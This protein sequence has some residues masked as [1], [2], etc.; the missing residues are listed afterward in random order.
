MD[1]PN[2][3]KRKM[4]MT[5]DEVM[6]T[7]LNMMLF[8]RKGARELGERDPDASGVDPVTGS[9]YQR[10]RGPKVPASLFGGAGD[11]LRAQTGPGAE[12][13]VLPGA[14][15]DSPLRPVL[16]GVHRQVGPGEEPSAG[17]QHQRVLR[18]RLRALR[19]ERGS[20]G[21]VLHAAGARSRL[22]GVQERLRL[23]LQEGRLLPDA[24][25]PGFRGALRGRLRGFRAGGPQRRA[26]LLPAQRQHPVLGRQRRGPFLPRPDGGRGRQVRPHGPGAGRHGVP[27]AHPGNGRPVRGPDAGGNEGQADAGAGGG[28]RDPPRPGPDPHGRGP[29]VH[30]RGRGLRQGP[31]LLAGNLAQLLQAAAGQHVPGVQARQAGHRRSCTT[32]AGTPPRSSTS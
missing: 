30:R 17:D 31:L 4:Y 21:P 9:K 14:G 18:P 15:S 24:G 12:S 6:Y 10:M 25:L 20:Q 32:A 27:V 23:H 19:H 2:I 1:V 11:H 5:P 28:L 22:H 13:A 8:F 3:G 7:D 29:D 16:A 26:A